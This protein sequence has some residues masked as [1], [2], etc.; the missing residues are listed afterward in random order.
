MG[1]KGKNKIEIRT[2]RTM[3]RKKMTKR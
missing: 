3:K 2:T 1:R